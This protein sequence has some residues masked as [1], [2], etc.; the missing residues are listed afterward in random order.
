MR[1]YFYLIL[2]VKF[3]KMAD[4]QIVAMRHTAKKVF[5][6]FECSVA[7]E[8]PEGSEREGRVF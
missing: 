2:T 3:S 1:L 5:Y 8:D 6:I 7:K 4:F